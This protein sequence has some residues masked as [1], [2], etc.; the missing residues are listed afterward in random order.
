MELHFSEKR[1][2][3]LHYK[4]YAARKT[5]ENDEQFLFWT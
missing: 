5:I 2:F 1:H 4:S 3:N